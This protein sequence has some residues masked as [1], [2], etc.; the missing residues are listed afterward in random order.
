MARKIADLQLK[1]F[2]FRS[3]LVSKRTA[4]LSANL[5]VGQLKDSPGHPGNT[6][7]YL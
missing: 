3:K 4:L 2:V 6:N 5:P 7:F 1:R